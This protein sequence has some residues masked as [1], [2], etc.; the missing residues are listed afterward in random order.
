M[1]KCCY[2]PKEAKKMKVIELV[3]N[4]RRI[5]ICNSCIEKHIRCAY[6]VVDNGS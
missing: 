6:K 5:K 2:C 4:K 3:R 1:E